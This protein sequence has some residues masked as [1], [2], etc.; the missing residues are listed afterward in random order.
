MQDMAKGSA[1]GT[2]EETSPAVFREKSAATIEIKPP[3]FSY[4]ITAMLV[5]G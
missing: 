3:L 1:C 5:T 4:G 2:S